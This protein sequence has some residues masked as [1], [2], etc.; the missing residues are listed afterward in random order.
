[1]N[2]SSIN[3]ALWLRARSL[4]SFIETSQQQPGRN[5]PSADITKPWLISLFGSSQSKLEK[6]RLIC[7]L[8]LAGRASKS[9]LFLSELILEICTFPD[10]HGHPLLS[11]Q[12]FHAA[13]TEPLDRSMYRNSTY[14]TRDVEKVSNWNGTSWRGQSHKC[15]VQMN[16]S[17]QYYQ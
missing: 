7:C 14:K 12:T 17:E 11:Q 4:C 9:G 6:A 8:I 5:F 13:L 1:M 10:S 3:S 16:D 2:V 15:C